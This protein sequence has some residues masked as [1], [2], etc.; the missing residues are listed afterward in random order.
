MYLDMYSSSN[1]FRWKIKCAGATGSWGIGRR[2]SPS[3]QGSSKFFIENHLVD[4]TVQCDWYSNVEMG[5][6]TGEGRRKESGDIYDMHSAGGALVLAET[7]AITVS[8]FSP[9]VIP[10]DPSV[11]DPILFPLPE[12]TDN[13][14]QPHPSGFLFL[15]V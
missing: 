5:T 6:E 2:V 7:M 9:D 10:S 15:S 11:L 13:L 3:S 14:L 12:A 8:A 4:N 1:Y